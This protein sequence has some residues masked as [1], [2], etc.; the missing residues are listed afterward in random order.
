M[1]LPILL[2][3]IYLILICKL[4]MDNRKAKKRQESLPRFAFSLQEAG[5]K[6]RRKIRKRI[7]R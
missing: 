6:V 3:I 7:N 2:F 5:P 4:I 1:V